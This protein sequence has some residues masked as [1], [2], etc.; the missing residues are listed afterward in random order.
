MPQRRVIYIAGLGHSG[1]TVLDMLLATRRKAVSLGQVWTVLCEDPLKSRTRVCT[2]GA[3][4]PDCDFWG[5]ILHRIDAAQG[6]LSQGDRY[7][8]VLERVEHL[9][10]PEMAVIDSSKQVANIKILANEIPELNLMVLH[11]IKDVRAFTISMMDNSIR[12]HNRRPSPEMLF[13]EWYRTNRMIHSSVC[14]VLGRPPFRVMYEALCFSTQAVAERMTELLG[15]Q[16]IDPAA[17]LKSGNNHIISGNRLRLSHSAEASSLTY[18]HRWFVRS[19]WLRP[20]FL[21]PMIRKYNEQCL[22]EWATS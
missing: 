12:K 7:Q 21:M 10:G 3:L 8:L 2:C 9:Y 5:P 22:R 20:Y 6:T 15:E 19:E 13:F 14:S 11:N 1:S 18:D 16:Y 17:A 4:A